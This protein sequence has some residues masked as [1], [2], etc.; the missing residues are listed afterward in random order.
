MIDYSILRV[1]QKTCPNYHVVSQ[2]NSKKSGVCV[3]SHC[4]KSR[5]GGDITHCGELMDRLRNLGH[6]VGHSRVDVNATCD[7]AVDIQME[8]PFDGVDN[9]E[10][11][12]K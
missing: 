2:G 12:F 3:C 9:G 10:E 6:P 11:I 7:R 8:L 4:V 1:M 5:K